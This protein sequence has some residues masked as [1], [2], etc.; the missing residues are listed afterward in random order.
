MWVEL[1]ISEFISDAFLKTL[2]DEVLQAFG[3]IMNFIDG[4]IEDLVKKGLD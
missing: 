4:V 1:R 2:R 3:F